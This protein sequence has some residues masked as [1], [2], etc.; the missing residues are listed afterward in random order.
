MV[1]FMLELPFKVTA[2]WFKAEDGV[3]GPE[4]ILVKLLM[5]C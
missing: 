1:F 3:I 4:H 2:W 5:K